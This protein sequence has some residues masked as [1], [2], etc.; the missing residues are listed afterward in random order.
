M[1]SPDR[2]DALRQNRNDLDT[3]EF[4]KAPD[5]DEAQTRDQRHRRENPSRGKREPKNG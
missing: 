5:T 1:T 3:K 4:D 2:Q